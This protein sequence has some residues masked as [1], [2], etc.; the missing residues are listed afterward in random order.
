MSGGAVGVDAM[1]RDAPTRGAREQGF[2]LVEVIVAG[3]VMM[4]VLIPSAMLL[5]SSAKVLTVTQAKIV[6][7]DLA[8]GVLEEDRAL[9]DSGPWSGSPP[10]PLLPSLCTTPPMGTQTVNGVVFTIGHC[11]GWC[12]QA[13]GA[14]ATTWADYAATPVAPP[15]YGVLVTVS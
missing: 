6:A 9:A 3:V 13:T 11:G 1:R 8:T 14:G 4:T 2:T 10:A 12:A 7:A 5:S 15:A